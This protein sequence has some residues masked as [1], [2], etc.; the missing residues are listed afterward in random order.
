MQACVVDKEAE[1][2]SVDS[3]L[4]YIPNLSIISSNMLID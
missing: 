3:L 1:N 4:F 2:H